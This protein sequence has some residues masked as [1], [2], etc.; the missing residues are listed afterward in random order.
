[1]A[2][3]KPLLEEFLRLKLPQ[4]FS[5]TEWLGDF[6]RKIRNA[7]DSD[8]VAAA[9]VILEKVELINEYSKRYHHSSN[10]AADTEIVDD[11]ELSNF[12][13]QTLDLVGGF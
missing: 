9:K 7:Q 1:M 8:P 5:D 10:P 2:P 11:A 4:A 3:G 13:K 12:A 6:I